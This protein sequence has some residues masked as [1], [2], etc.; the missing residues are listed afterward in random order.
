MKTI[1]SIINK[2][3]L[4]SFFLLAFALSWILWI[5]LMYGHF[6]LGWTSWEGNSWKNYKTMLGIL[7]SLGPALSA[8]I[9]TYLLDGK[10]KVQ[11]LLKSV[12]LWK[13]NIFWWL[14]VLYGWWLLCSVLAVVLNLSETQNVLQNFLYSLINIPAMMFILQLPLLIGIFGEEVGWRGFALPKL[15]E[16]YNPIIASFILALPWILWHAPLFVFQEWRGNS[17]LFDFFLNYFL[18]VIPLTLIFTWVFQKTRGSLLFVILLHKSY[19]L[20]FNG[21]KIALGLSEE[22]SMVL[23][24]W[25]IIVLWIIAGAITIYYLK[26]NKKRKQN[27]SDNLEYLKYNV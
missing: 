9:I 1:K 19:N 20:T 21:F 4:F 23:R 3:P 2:H 8:L 26:I 24:E 5:P 11:S 22:N 25:S 16:K 6:K 13:F 17:S 18:L 12:V 27:G 10:T 14:L 15:L 7:G